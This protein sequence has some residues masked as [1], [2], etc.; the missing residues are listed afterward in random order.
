[1]AHRDGSRG[2][3]SPSRLGVGCDPRQDGPAGGRQPFGLGG[4]QAA[5]DP[6][7]GNAVA[8]EDSGVNNDFKFLPVDSNRGFCR[9]L[10]C[11]FDPSRPQFFLNRP[12]TSKRITAPM[13][14]LMIAAMT[15]PT[16]T[17]PTSGKSQPAMRAP[18]MPTMMLPTS[19]KP[20]PLTSRPASQPAT[21]P[22]TSQIMRSM[23]MTVSPGYADTS[24]AFPI[25]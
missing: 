19:P 1:R 2:V 17:K 9:L 8:A 4:G 16:M 18:I 22:M 15:P 24:P 25:R 10:E 13:T 21:P 23:I 3:V 12:I 14:A 7:P 6:G 5:A 20:E 11:G